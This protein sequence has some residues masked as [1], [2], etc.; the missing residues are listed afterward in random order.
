MAWVGFVLVLRLSSVAGA[1]MPIFS[2]AS[3]NV[4]RCLCGHG[5]QACFATASIKEAFWFGAP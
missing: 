1:A 5:K 4:F 2:S 3:R